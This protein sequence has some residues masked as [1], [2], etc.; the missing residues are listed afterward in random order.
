VY[1]HLGLVEESINAGQIVAFG[2]G[3]AGT[4]ILYK[5][6]IPRDAVGFSTLT[7][8]VSAIL[9]YLSEKPISSNPYYAFAGGAL[10]SSLVVFVKDRP[11]STG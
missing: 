10:L 5:V 6:T 7:G 2:A 1:N 11:P 9:G 3:V 4:A 8:V